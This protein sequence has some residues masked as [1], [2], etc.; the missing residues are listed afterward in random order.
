MRSSTYFLLLY[1]SVLSLSP[2]LSL[3]HDLFPLRSTMQSL[4]VSV[5]SWHS[6]NVSLGVDPFDEDH[7]EK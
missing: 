2:F 4:F 3:V 7:F 5:A 6:G 1:K